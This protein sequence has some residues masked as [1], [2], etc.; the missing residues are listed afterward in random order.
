MSEHVVERYLSGQVALVT[1]AAQG[2][3]AE[4]ARAFAETG[5]RVAVLDRDDIIPRRIMRILESIFG[6]EYQ[7]EGD[8]FLA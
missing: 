6:V 5:A 3:G 4:V 1:G 7:A 2:I 8:A